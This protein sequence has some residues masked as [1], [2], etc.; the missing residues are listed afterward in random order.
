LIAGAFASPTATSAPAQTASADCKVSKYDKE[1]QITLKDNSKF[2]IS[3]GWSFDPEQQK[4][5]SP[6]NDFSLNLLKVPNTGSAEEL[7]KKAWQTVH[8]DIAYPILQTDHPP[9][10]HGWEDTHRIVY[11]V[12]TAENRNILAVLRVFQ[13]NAYIM[14]LDGTNSAFDRRGAQIQVVADTWRPD[15]LKEEFLG[16]KEAKAFGDADAVEFDKF[17]TKSMKT[18][19]V[20]GATV[21][22]VQKGKVVYRKGFGVK[23]LGESDPVQ[24]ETMFMIGSIT[25]PLTT[26]ML[27]KLVES[28]KLS[29]ET[30]IVKALP[31]FGLADK[32]VTPKFLIKHTACA[33]T[34]MPRR[35]F[36]EMFGSKI[37]SVDDTLEQLHSTK[38][39][40]GFG[41]VFQY[42]NQLVAVGGLAGANVYG[43]GTNLFNKYENA[44]TDLVFEPLQMTCTRVKPMDSDLKNLSSPH[45]TKYDG[46][47]GVIAQDFDDTIY[48][49]APAGCLWSNIDDMAKYVLMELR[50]GKDASGKVLFS[51]EQIIKRRTPGVK[52]DDYTRYGL[53]LFI[54]ND[55]GV[56][57]IHHGGNTNGF[58]ADMLFLPEQEI[59]F[60][61]LTNGG[62][63]NGY[64]SAMRQKLFELMLAAE[65]KADKMV[66]NTD[67]TFKKMQAK[68]RDRV[69]TEKSEVAWID[70]YVGHYENKDLGPV[71]VKKSADGGY[72][73]VTPHWKSDLGSAKEQNGTRLIALIDPPWWWGSEFEAHKA[74]ASTPRKLTLNDAQLKYEFKEVK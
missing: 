41:E 50:K 18:L 39:T 63:V 15:G 26:L 74:T 27:S 58:T 12:P 52:V 66:Q 20:P 25:K 56:T 10:K 46:T 67:E 11:E 38:P 37:H 55:R 40:T 31:A 29:W 36:E 32:A 2:T 72:Q 49:I 57:V 4:L 30:P 71:E 28:G 14:L 8:H 59:G 64:R 47:A 70:E 44:M 17:I 19:D 9:S 48:T 13:G 21:I 23:R 35:D 68:M 62:H 24:P 16:D 5:V 43:K 51:E 1:A 61:S 3:A 7:I 53:G 33:C 60:V 34:G 42:S 45:A 73:F 54:Q 6:E 65:P 22:I 69:T